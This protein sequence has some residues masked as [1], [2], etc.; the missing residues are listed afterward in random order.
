MWDF[1]DSNLEVFE[2][3]ITMILSLNPIVDKYPIGT[4]VSTNVGTMRINY[5][6]DPVPYCRAI[7]AK[8]YNIP[9]T[10]TLEQVNSL[11]DIYLSLN[12]DY[13]VD[14]LVTKILAY[15]GN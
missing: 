12:I 13:T 2:Q 14:P 9:F 6:T 3:L 11:K 15:Y 4:A 1:S 8:Q 7:W 10:G 5:I